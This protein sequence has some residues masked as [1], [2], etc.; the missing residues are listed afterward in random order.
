MTETAEGVLLHVDP[1]TLV[2]ETNVRTQAGVTKQFVASIKENGVLTPITAVRGEDGTLMVRAGQRRTL[3]AREAELA[4]VPVYVIPDDSDEATRVVDQVTENDHRLGLPQSD[5]VKS[6]QQLLDMGLSVTKVAK[7]LAV[8][9]ERV[10]QSKAVADSTLAM[11]SLNGGA[12]LAEAAGIAEFSDDV[13]AVERLMRAAG[14]NYFDHELQRQR[15][16][17]DEARARAKAAAEYVE[18]GYEVL[19]QYPS[20]D[21]VHVPLNHL[22]TADGEP[23]DESVVTDPKNWALTLTEYEVFLNAE[24]EEVDETLIDW[25]TQEDPE[26]VPQEGMLHADTITVAEVWVPQDYFCVDP[27]GVGLKVS[28]RYLKLSAAAA[29]LPEGQQLESSEDLAR[30]AEERAERRKTMTLNKAG[31]AAMTVRREFV[32]AMLKRKTAPDGA[33]LFVASA[34]SHD[35]TLLGGHRGDQ[36]AGELLGGDVRDGALLDHASDNRAQVIVLGLTLGAM[37]AQ[38]SKSA[39]RTPGAWTGKYLRF[40]AANGYGLS[41]VERVMIG[42]MTPDECLEELA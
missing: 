12:T 37:E 1:N 32:T 39:W 11:E 28:D 18:L 8:S 31:E 4:T 36:V 29:N 14:H 16:I 42:E 19:D 33:A 25:A 34:L 17:R 23:A 13:V 9:S 30:K 5:R 6:I 41:P 26:A 21:G 27:E 10:K 3:A 2:L 22:C 35:G 15:Q 20:Y 24:G 7:R 38:T 40:L